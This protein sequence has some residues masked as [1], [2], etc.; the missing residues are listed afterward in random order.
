MQDETLTEPLP[1]PRPRRALTT[2]LVALLAF[3][4]GGVAVGWLVNSGNLPY[5]LP[6]NTASKAPPAQ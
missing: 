3:A 1:L 5:A 6:G 2:V 4:L